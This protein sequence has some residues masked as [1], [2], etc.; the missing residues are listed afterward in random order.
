VTELDGILKTA[1][2]WVVTRSGGCVISSRIRL[3]RNLAG[4]VFP[5][6]AP[7]DERRRVFER[8]AN[9]LSEPD[10]LPDV[11]VLPLD[12]LS[13][14]DRE[15]LHERR[16]ISRE[17]VVK[18]SACGLVVSAKQRIAVMINEEDHLRMQ[19]LRPG[20]NLLKAWKIL[21]RLDSELER[22]VKYAFSPELGY[23]T[24]CPS[25]VGTGLRAS[26]MLHLP[27]LKLMNEIDRVVKGMNRMGLAVRGM[28]GE[29]SQD[30]SSMYQISNQTTLG[31]TEEDTLRR[32]LDIAETLVDIE[33]NARLRLIGQR[34]VF[35]EDYISR[36]VGIVRHS[37]IMSSGEALDLL[38]AIHLGLDFKMVTGVSLSR[39]NELILLVQP[40]HMQKRAGRQLTVEERDMLRSLLVH[41]RL[42]SV[43]LT[44]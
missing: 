2:S 41:E 4:S 23:L 11:A 17:M 34:R 24:S 32:V 29:G 30:Y 1:R 8:L 36:A 12:D 5:G 35:V 28:F 33:R 37:K 7:L 25:N 31:M 42:Q 43:K 40:G 44:I 16:L 18:N 39:I 26:V 14:V 9:I 27:G 6:Q 22:H 10:M 15:M 20:L 13:P 21:D 3:A 19:I 38:S